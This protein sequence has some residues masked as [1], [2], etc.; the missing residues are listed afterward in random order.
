MNETRYLDEVPVERSRVRG[1]SVRQY[2]TFMVIIIVIK[3]AYEIYYQILD[4]INSITTCEVHS[5]VSA[6]WY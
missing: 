6:N 3:H 4:T 1:K 5:N 2:F